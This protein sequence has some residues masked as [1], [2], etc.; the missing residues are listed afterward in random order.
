MDLLSVIFFIVSLFATQE[1]YKTFADETDTDGVA[2][3]Y[4]IGAVFIML[5]MSLAC[6]DMADKAAVIA[7]ASIGAMSI[8]LAEWVR[9]HP[10]H[11]RDS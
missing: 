7:F 4:L 5:G 1:A 3:F 2:A 9:R 10:H 8:G 11:F 6:M